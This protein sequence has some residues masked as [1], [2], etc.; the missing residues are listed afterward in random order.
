MPAMKILLLNDRIPPEGKGGAESVVWRLAQDLR[1]QGHAVHIAA[2]THGEPF[3]DTREGIPT[4]HLH[5]HYRERFQSWLSLCN[6]QTTGA[7]RRLLERI[8][9]DVVNAHNIHAWLSWHTLRQA[10]AAGCGVVFSGHDCMSV[11]YGKMRY[12]ARPDKDEITLQDY[13]LP[14]GY[15]LRHNRFRYNPL[16][17]IAI[18]RAMTHA[19]AITAPS[20]ALA[21]FYA[22]NGLPAPTVVP[23]GVDLDT[24]T[25]ASADVVSR[26]RERYGLHGKRVILAAGRLTADKGMIQLLEALE[27]LRENLPEARLLV[28]SSRG[29]DKQIPAGFRHLRELVIAGGWL[30]GEELRAAFQLADVVT[31]PSVIFDT[32]PTVNLEALAL[33]TPVVATCFG[34]SRELVIDGECGYIVNPFDIDLLARRIVDLLADESLRKRMGENGRRRVAAHFTLRRQLARMVEIYRLAVRKQNL[35]LKR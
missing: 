21:D 4:H 22:A 10:R 13:R 23:N 2:A 8:R 26:L 3:D 1:A 33:G 27:R 12:I 32:F 31:T 17:N 9:P 19:H 15:N 34:G 16:R 29:V 5:A 30:E 24:W 14:R 18:R 6:P 25:P 28:L 11:V 20:Q 7:F 35:E